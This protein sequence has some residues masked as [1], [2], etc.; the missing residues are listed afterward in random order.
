MFVGIF[1]IKYIVLLPKM[2]NLLIN[3]VYLLT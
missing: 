2:L 1:S 3:S